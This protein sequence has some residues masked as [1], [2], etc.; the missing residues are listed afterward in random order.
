MLCIIKKPI[1]RYMTTLPT[2]IRLLTGSWIWFQRYCQ[3]E[4]E[5]KDAPK[6]LTLWLVGHVQILK[7]WLAE[8]NQGSWFS[9]FSTFGSSARSHGYDLKGLHASEYKRTEV[10]E[11]FMFEKILVLEMY[12]QLNEICELV[13]CKICYYGNKNERKNEEWHFNSDL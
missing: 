9:L 2:T 10:R 6:Q 3:T 12:L 8:P 13:L 4:C 1:S 11:R 7:L 5:L